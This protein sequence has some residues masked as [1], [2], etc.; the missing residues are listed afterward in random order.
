MSGFPIA[1]EIE[2]RVI[3]SVECKKL[4]HNQSQSKMPPSELLQRNQPNPF[5]N[6]GDALDGWKERVKVS[7]DLEERDGLEDLADETGDEYGYTAKFE[8]GTSQALGP[9]T[10]DQIDKG[11][12]RSDLERD[13][14]TAD[15]KDPTT[16]MEIEMQPS[17]ALPVR[18]AALNPENSVKSQL[19]MSESDN[20]LGESTE[21]NDDHEINNS[22][23]STVSVRR[24]YMTEDI[25][26]LSKLSMKDNELGKAHG[27]EMSAD[28]RDDA[29][30]LWR[31]Y[32]LLTSRLSQELAE[33]LRLVMEPTSASKLQGYYKTG[34]RIDMKKVMAYFASYFQNSNMWLRWTRPNKR[35]YQ[36]VIA[37]DDSRSMSESR[38]GGVAIEA[39]VTVCRTMSQLE[40]GKSAVA[41]FGQKGNVRL[42]H[43]FDQ[44]FTGEAGIKIISSLTFEQENTIVDDPM[45]DLL[46]YLNNMLDTAVMNARLPCGYNPLQQLVL[47]I[48]DGRFHQKDHVKRCVR[49]ILSKMRMV[50]FILIDSPHEPI[51]N[52]KEVTFSREEFSKGN[53]KFSKYLDS[54]PFPFYVV[55]KNIEAL[56]RTVADLLR[57]WFE[58]MQN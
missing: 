13:I 55:L 17:D 42:L 33:Q 58:L 10:A 46:R 27:F 4:S 52:L 12:N 19:E 11:M 3:D 1:S 22:S 49:D 44:P 40:V 6:F 47:I 14:G 45:V 34:K 30:A 18:T 28:L 37:V 25:N 36:V 38:C 53:I 48:S 50:A 57:Q 16:D 29:A 43:D 21:V 51:M 31:R 35:D 54:F 56:P 15:S 20:P 41:S 26:Q 8:K 32:E 5:R 2:M 39:L 23:E 9:A 7:V 24:S